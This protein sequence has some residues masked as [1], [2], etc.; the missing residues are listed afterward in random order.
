MNQTAFKN[1]VKVSAFVLTIVMLLGLVLPFSLNGKAEG[2]PTQAE[3]I[4]YMSAHPVD[5]DAPTEYAEKPV[6]KAPYEEIGALTESTYQ[7]FIN[8]INQA[9]FVAGLNEVQ[10]DATLSLLEQLTAMINA[11]NDELNHN[12]AQPAGMSDEMYELGFEGAQSSNLAMGFPGPAAAVF[13]GWLYDSDEYNIEVLGHRRWILSPSMKETGFGQV[14]DYSAM[15]VFDWS[16]ETQP[17]AWPAKNMP[18][19]MFSEGEAWSYLLGRELTDTELNNVQVSLKNSNTRRVYSFSTDQGNL[20]F[21]NDICGMPGAIIFAPTKREIPGYYD[22]DAYDVTITGLNEGTVSYHVDFFDTDLVMTASLTS[23]KGTALAVDS[24]TTLTATVENG[25]APYTYKF[26]VHNTQTDG[27]YKIQDFGS[28][29]TCDWYTGTAGD[30][31]LYVDVKD[32]SGTVVRQE[33]NVTI[34]ESAAE[35]LAV[36]SF[37]SSKGTSL[38]EKTNTTLTANATGGKSPYTYKFIVYNT[39]TKEWYKIRDFASPNTC[40]WYAGAAGNKTLYVDVKDSTGKVERRALDVM[41]SASSPTPLTV[42]SFTSSKGTSLSTRSNTTLTAKANGGKAP[43]TYKFIVYNTQTK[44]WYKIRDF[45]SSNACNW[46]TGATGNKVLYVDVKDS[47][48]TVKR[49]ALDVT[50]K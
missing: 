48:G 14:G 8:S 12:P 30:K 11:A 1:S 41:V 22:G 18:V 42:T 38:T 29:N 49:Q 26:I 31:T 20:F 17:V 43:Y 13:D 3:I 32:A 28:S 50:V 34:S 44:E 15:Y 2:C 9:R 21:D 7:N 45:E 36:T 47:A 5:R 46:H 10:L 4:Q 24:H 35:P 39:Q 23:S 19:N 40:D 16:E 37:E 27:W 33:L 6:M 25:K